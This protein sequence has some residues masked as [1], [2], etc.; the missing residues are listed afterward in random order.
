MD[1]KS[2]FVNVAVMAPVNVCLP[3]L[4]NLFLEHGGIYILSVPMQTE[5]TVGSILDPTGKRQVEISMLFIFQLSKETLEKWTGE[6]YDPKAVY[7]MERFF[8]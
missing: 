2:H 4:L 1:L 3:M 7:A 6:K 5:K 8:K